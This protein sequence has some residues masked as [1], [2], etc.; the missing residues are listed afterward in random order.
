MSRSTVLALLSVASLLVVPTASAA[1]LPTWKIRDC[2]H[3]HGYDA[4]A[5]G[6]RTALK[7]HQPLTPKLG[8]RA[9]H[10]VLC[11]DSPLNSKRLRN[12]HTAW[13]R[14]RHSTHWRAPHLYAIRF[15]SFEP[16]VRSWLARIAQCESHGDP[17]AVGGGGAYRGKFQFSFSTWRV[18]GGYGDPVAAHEWEQDYRAAL[19]L[20]RYGSQH[21]PICAG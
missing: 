20:T 13:L 18:V 4:A 12:Q 10:F 11:T 3:G 6:L 21:W 2:S 5:R 15:N 8:R 7:H 19:L 9:W 17:H 1:D 14:W 16:W